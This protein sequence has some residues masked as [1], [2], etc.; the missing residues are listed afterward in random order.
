MDWL[1]ARRN[2]KQ[3]AKVR[4]VKILAFVLKRGLTQRWTCND[5][6]DV[7]PVLARPSS[8]TSITVNPSH[9]VDV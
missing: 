6:A 5:Y 9:L 2:G 4:R 8:A 1:S 3:E 7:L